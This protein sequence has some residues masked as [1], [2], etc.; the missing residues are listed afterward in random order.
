[1]KAMILDENLNFLWT[2]VPD[3]GRKDNEVLIEVHAAAVN[4]ADLMQKDGCYSSP[5]DW[6]QWCGL[7]VAGTIA[8]AGEDSEFKV[9]DRVAALIGGGGYSEKIA[10]PEGM[11]IH[12]PDAMVNYSI[13]ITFETDVPNN[14]Q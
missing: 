7:E 5:P 11:V 14:N 1:M 13:M 6:P 2:D 10:V 8:E 12:I 4:R 3:P 9:G